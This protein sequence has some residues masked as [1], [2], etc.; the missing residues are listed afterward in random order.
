[1]YDSFGRRCP[2]H[3][4]VSH[5][6]PICATPGTTAATP[7]N[8]VLAGVNYQTESAVPYNTPAPRVLKHDPLLGLAD[9]LGLDE[10]LDDPRDR[11]RPLPSLPIRL[12]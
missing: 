4:T 2:I 7:S 1:M 6:C 3:T 12:L 11:V 10:H 9:S 5:P 8:V